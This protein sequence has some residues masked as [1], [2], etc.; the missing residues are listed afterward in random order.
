MDSQ[1]KEKLLEE[2]KKQVLACKQCPL[3]LTR[4]NPVF[5]EGNIESKIMFIGEAPGVNED[6]QGV[7]FCGAAGKILDELLASVGIKRNDVYITNILKCRPPENRDPKPEEIS[8]C[9]PYLEKQIEIINPRVICSL[10]RYSMK[11]IFEKYGLKE[12]LEPI[13]KIHGKVF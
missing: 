3:Y 5:G 12:K 2:V 10:G 8:V 1:E 4:T 9:T 7:P 6:K 13:S 11:F